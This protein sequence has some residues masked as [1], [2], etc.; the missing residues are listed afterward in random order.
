MKDITEMTAR[1]LLVGLM[2]GDRATL[3]QGYGPKA[4]TLAV[5][6]LQN[7]ARPSPI[8]ERLLAFAEGYAFAANDEGVLS[9]NNRTPS[10]DD[11]VLERK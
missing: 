10:P 2:R 11:D 1:E 7:I 9:N 3:K 6:D 4:A 8:E 5:C